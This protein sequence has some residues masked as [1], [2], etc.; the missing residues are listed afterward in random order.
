MNPL[1][2]A[3]VGLGGYAQAHLQ[4]V[5]WLA[6]Q[7]LARLAAVIA[8]PQ[9]RD[10]HPD[11]LK[12]ARQKQARLFDSLDAF[13]QSGTDEVDVLCLPIGIH[14]HAEVSIRAMQAGL[15]VYCEKPAAA[16]VQDVDRM[17][18]A[19]DRH[20]RKMT[21]GFQY[22]LGPAIARAKER[23]VSGKLG[24]PLQATLVCT[25]PRSWQYY[26]RNGWAGRLQADG[27]WVLD[28]PANGAMAHS[29]M[30][31]LYLASP[32]AGRAAE[33]RWVQAELYRAYAIESADT[34]QLKF[35]T[36]TG[37]QAH[38][39]LSH[40]TREAIGPVLEMQFEH[41][42]VRFEGHDGRSAIRYAAG[43]TETFEN[44]P[45]IW[46]FELFCDLVLAIRDDRPVACPPELTRPHTLLVNGMHESGA[47][48]VTIPQ[49][50]LYEETGPRIWPPGSTGRFRRV[51][52][53]E[54]HIRT[55]LAQ[56]RFFSELD[57]E[58][59]RARSRFE[60]TSYVHFPHFDG[61]FAVWR[62]PSRNA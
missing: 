59:A 40:A 34:A 42:Q 10:A 36:D 2:F 1:N 24:K 27:R 56:D 51:R 35:A 11:W 32:L 55:A 21:I 18:A 57:I 19:R 39:I 4:A 6:Q 46:R 26:Q 23:I 44:T 30:N 47:P 29:I 60:M 8:R 48:I 28:S 7:G 22:L 14:E 33:P 25:W 41:G 43:R 9:D 31:L 5:D 53:L 38:V 17:I 13:W 54:H 49:Q 15:H 16:T 37:V 62:P 50:H 3:V 61:L 45:E 58:W 12:H 52:D 20:R